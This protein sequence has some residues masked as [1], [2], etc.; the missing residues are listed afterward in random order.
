[1]DLAFKIQKTNLEIR[2]RIFKIPSVPIFKQNEQIWLFWPKFAQKGIYSWELIKPML[3]QES[4]SSR[5]D[6]CQF[7]VKTDN[8]D[9]FGPNLLK[10]EIRIWNSEN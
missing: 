8:F 5:Y 7:S 4:A 2:I 6:L 3:K 10:N 1:M 9:F